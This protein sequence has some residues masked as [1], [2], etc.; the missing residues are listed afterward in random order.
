MVLEAWD[1]DLEQ[2]HSFG[3][4]PSENNA[5]A[6]EPVSITKL[7][8]EAYLYQIYFPFYK[9]ERNYD[10]PNIFYYRGQL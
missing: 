3:I 10:N 9:K 5:V 1:L 4:I 2:V 6:S 7:P 8:L